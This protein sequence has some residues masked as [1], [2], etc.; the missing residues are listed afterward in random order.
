MYYDKGNSLKIKKWFLCSGVV[1]YIET[2]GELNITHIPS[3]GMAGLPSGTKTALYVSG[4]L[5]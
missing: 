4:K 2:A 1:L 3:A 5:N